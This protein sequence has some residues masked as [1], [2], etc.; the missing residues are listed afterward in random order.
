[1]AVLSAGPRHSLKKLQKIPRPGNSRKREISGPG[2]NFSGR[3]GPARPGPAGES[4]EFAEMRKRSFPGAKT[5][6]LRSRSE[7]KSPKLGIRRSGV[8]DILPPAGRRPKAGGLCP[9]PPPPF[10]LG[11]PAEKFSKKFSKPEDNK[12]SGRQISIN[13]LFEWEASH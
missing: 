6:R 4:R 2:E 10:F 9:P 13:D 5:F 8:A 1:M 7:R 11:G 3:P 12:Q